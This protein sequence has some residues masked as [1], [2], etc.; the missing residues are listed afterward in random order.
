MAHF[1][2]VVNNVVQNVIVAEQDFIDSVMTPAHPEG[3]WIQTSYNTRGGVHYEPNGGPPSADQTKALR[4]NFAGTGD[5][6]DPDA[7]AFYSPAPFPS[8]V[9]N[10]NTYMWEPPVEYPGVVG[11]DPRYDWDED[12]GSWVEYTG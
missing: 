7:D 1:A 4:Y 2:L 11:E 5:N 6:Y 3:Q 12:S 8:W 9:L 10:T